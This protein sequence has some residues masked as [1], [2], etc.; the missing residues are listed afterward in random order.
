MRTALAIVLSSLG[1]TASAQTTLIGPA[2]YLSENDSPW[3]GMPGL[4]LEDCED[5]AFDIPGVLPS[6]GEVI[7]N[8]INVDS[9]DADDGAIDGFGRDGHSFFAATGSNVGI[10]FTFD[11]DIIGRLPTHAGVVWTDGLGDVRFEAFDGDGV[12]LGVLAG[13]H[14][15]SSTWG[16]TAEDRFYG[17]EHPGGIGA[18]LISNDSTG[19]EI[20]HL[21]YVAPAGC[22]PADIA[23]P[24]GLL[25]LND[26]TTFIAAFVDHDPIADLD[27]NGLLDLNDVNIFVSSFLAGCP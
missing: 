14:A 8:A 9:V 18:I 1:S 25:D 5:D 21:Q 13:F 10:L 15:D 22:N 24:L 4:V 17:V 2:P 27:S 6:D 7:G 20:D 3:Y 11:P 16:E 26:V 19:I 12:S 23:E